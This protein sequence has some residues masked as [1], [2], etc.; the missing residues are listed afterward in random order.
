MSNE[1]NLKVKVKVDSS[2][3]DKLS[4]KLKGINT[5]GETGGTSASSGGEPAAA[6][7]AKKVKASVEEMTAA[8]KYAAEVSK[9]LG[10]EQNQLATNVDA[11]EIAQKAFGA[12]LQSFAGISSVAIGATLAI[13][14]ATYQLSRKWLDMAVLYPPPSP[15]SIVRNRQ[16][17]FIEL[18][19]HDGKM[20]SQTNHHELSLWQKRLTAYDDSIQRHIFEC[21]GARDRKSTR[22]NSSHQI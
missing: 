1:S 21:L 9:I 10:E 14:S 5:V 22:L 15:G 18:R 20:L 4:S 12:A 17:P 6:Q 3:L 16:C 11:A 7:S 13:G 2:E 8:Q 19:G